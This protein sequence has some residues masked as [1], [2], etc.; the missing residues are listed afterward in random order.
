MILKKPY[1]FLI[2]HFKMIHVILTGLYI[3]L[4]FKVSSILNFYNGYIDGSVGKLRAIE[5]INNTP[6][7][8]IGVSFIVC[9]ILFILMRYKKKPKLL[10]FVL[11]MLYILVYAVIFM[12]YNGLNTIYNSVLDTKTLLLY[13]DFLR[14]IIVFQYISIIFTTIRAIGFDIKK[15]NFSEDINSLELD[16]SDA[17]EVELVMGVDQHKLTQKF[18]RSLREVRY[19]IVENK[20]FVILLIIILIGI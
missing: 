4:A 18:N 20:I 7:I 8:I 5:Y 6:F 10:Y 17:E 13:R 2:K 1:A 11:S 15:F 14:I 19:Y 16:V 12:S 9:F 3:Y